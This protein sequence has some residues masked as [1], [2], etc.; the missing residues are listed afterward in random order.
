[1]KKILF[2][3]IAMITVSTSMVSFN[4]CDDGETYADMKE[5]EKKAIRRFLDDNDFVGKIKVINESEFYANDTITD[6]ARNEFVLFE[7]DGVYMQI[8]RK[9][10]GRTM[11]EMAKEQED[12]TISKMLL[13]RFLEYDILGAD[14]TYTNYFTPTIVDKILCKYT[15]RSRSYTGAFTEGYMMSGYGASVPSGWLKPIDYIRL[16]RNAGRI[17]KVR[18][19][20]PHSSGT[21]NASQYVLPCYYEISFQLGK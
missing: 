10:E 14:T 13:C 15:H 2:Y 9:G 8:V 4:S 19:I 16:T 3:V 12:S 18:L 21:T 1:M 11:V 17:A 5:K 20:V 7:E 6:T